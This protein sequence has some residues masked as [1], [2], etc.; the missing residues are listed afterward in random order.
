MSD[1]TPI[2]RQAEFEAA[3]DRAQAM[4]D[5]TRNV[6]AE[7]EARGAP[8][9]TWQLPQP[10]PQPVQRQREP[11]PK[12][13]AEMSPPWP[14]KVQIIKHD[15]AGRAVAVITHEGAMSIKAALGWEQF[16]ADSIKAALDRRIPKAAEAIGEGLGEAM[17]EYAKRDRER[18]D[19]L[20]A[21]VNALRSQVATLEERLRQAETRVAGPPRLVGESDAA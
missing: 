17:A 6:L 7:R 1:D 15:A 18:V 11:E 12:P 3:R 14:D 5:E 8:A 2:W 19:A 9:F 16:V 4:L 21:A 10:E 20:A 13:R